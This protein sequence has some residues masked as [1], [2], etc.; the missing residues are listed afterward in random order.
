MEDSNVLA[1]ER[2]LSH[3]ERTQ[4]QS[5]FEAVLLKFCY[6]MQLRACRIVFELFNEL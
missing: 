6:P 3:F 1:L 5:E 4:I 2:A